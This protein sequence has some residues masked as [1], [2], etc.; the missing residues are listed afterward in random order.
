[1]RRDLT[2]KVAIITGASSGIGAA[3]ALAMAQAGVDIALVARRRE[4]L[5]EVAKSI[6]AIGR[7][8]HVIVDDVADSAHAQRILDETEAVLGRI[9]IVFA[10]AGYGMERPIHE[11]S[12]DEVRTMFEVNFFASLALVRAAAKHLLRAQRPG[13]LL[14]CSSC[15]SKFS[16][17]GHGLY[18]ATKAA[19]ESVCRAMRFELAR[20]GIEVAS[21]HPVT[22]TSE[23]YRASAARSGLAPGDIPAHSRRMF[24]QS[25]ERVARAVVACLRQPR[26]EVWTS[27]TVR[28]SAALFTL[29][30]SMLDMVMR[31]EA[32]RQHREQATRVAP[33]RASVPPA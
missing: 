12:D 24:V 14:M 9:D 20:S 22:T 23:F 25:P 27:W 2:D 18:A 16:L 31:R 6:R 13:H 26:S 3:T 7:R 33:T 17:P 8:A 29:C 30:P 19:Q 32:R 15:L 10:N 1:M 5:E 11:M 21:V 4:K 28:F